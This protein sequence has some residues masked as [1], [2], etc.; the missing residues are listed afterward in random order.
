M[1]AKG[2]VLFIILFKV[3]QT[4]IGGIKFMFLDNFIQQQ[5]PKLQK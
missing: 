2:K 1:E 5:Q 3:R 4:F